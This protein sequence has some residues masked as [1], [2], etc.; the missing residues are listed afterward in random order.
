MW[1]S[2]MHRGRMVLLHGDHGC[3]ARRRDGQDER[4]ADKTVSRPRDEQSCSPGG[5]AM[6]PRSALDGDSRGGLPRDFLFNIN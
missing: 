6:G 4:E 5:D 2:A 3:T 1:R